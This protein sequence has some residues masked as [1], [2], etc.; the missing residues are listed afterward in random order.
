[1]LFNFIT[2]FPE[3]INA[4]FKNGLPGKA[5]ENNLIRINPVDL[6]EFSGNKHGRVDDTIYG[7]GPGMLLRIDP[8]H[9]AILSLQENAGH[10]I[11]TSPSGKPF[12]QKMVGEI[13]EKYDKLTIISGYYEGVDN[14]ITQH[15]VD[16]EISI[17]NY[18]L[19]SGDLA[20]LCIVDAVIRMVPGFMGTRD[21]LKEESHVIE[22]VLEYPQFTKPPEY[23]GWKVPEVLLGGNHAEIDKWRLANRK[24]LEK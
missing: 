19:S 16:T 20:S 5:I 11:L 8:V 3:K 18:V 24:K 4:Y 2:L 22:N 6:R 1:M 14:R 23:N 10:V 21:S 17:G 12:N 13:Y 7:G 9:R 15:L